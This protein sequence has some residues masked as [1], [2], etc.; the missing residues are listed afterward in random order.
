MA[1]CLW[2]G[3]RTKRASRT[4]GNDLKPASI[5]AR[6]ATVRV[7]GLKLWR[8]TYYTVDPMGPDV[9]HNGPEW[10][11]P[12][13]WEPL[14]RL[15][16]RTFYVQPGHCFCLGDNSPESSDSRHWGLVPERLVLGK[17]VMVYYPFSRVRLIE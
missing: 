8:D 5:G 17:A 15:P 9:G 14:Q 10:D 6:G 4:D 11:D 12:E 13:T 3:R 2:R 16:A 1:V 7:G